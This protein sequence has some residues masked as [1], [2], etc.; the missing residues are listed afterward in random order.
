MPCDEDTSHICAKQ[1][2]QW[3]ACLNKVF[4]NGNA[5]KAAQ[6]MATCADERA[7]FDQCVQEWRAEVG[8]A[9]RLRG[10]NPGEPPVQCGPIACLYETCMAA[11]TYK[12][13]HCTGAMQQFKHC[14]K[15]LHG[16]EY[17]LD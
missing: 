12:F 2:K 15:G 8:S 1:A 14:V 13:E 5:T 7:Y 3:R 10:P 16:S 4:Q 6:S 11:N 9:V 17:V